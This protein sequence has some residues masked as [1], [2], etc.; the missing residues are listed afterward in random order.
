MHI[1]FM[2][3]RVEYNTS[4]PYYHDYHRIQNFQYSR[5]VTQIQFLQ[6][7]VMKTRRRY[8]LELIANER[9]TR[10][11][12][13][14]FA[15]VANE[16]ESTL[17]IQFRDPSGSACNQRYLETLCVAQRTRLAENR[18]DRGKLSN[19]GSSRV[20]LRAPC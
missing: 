4:L 7:T 18:I 12:L 10:E 17:S 2:V 6:T 13:V 5:I 3:Q 9:S 11:P 8:L 19:T 14:P 20:Y 1:A 16:E 15:R